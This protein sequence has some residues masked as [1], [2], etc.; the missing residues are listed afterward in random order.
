MSRTGLS[1][2]QQASAHAGLGLFLLECVL[3]GDPNGVAAASSAADTAA[4]AATAPDSGPTDA[5]SGAVETQPGETTDDS[6]PTPDSSESAEDQGEAEGLESEDDQPRNDDERKLSRRER[7]RLREQE[8]IDKAIADALAAKDREREQAEETRKR[9]ETAT[10]AE[11]ARRERVS[12]FVGTQEALTSLNSEIDTLQKQI[13]D[14]IV[15]PNG[16]DLEDLIAQANAKRAHRDRWLENQSFQTELQADIWSQIEADYAYPATFPELADPKARAAY[17][18]SQGGIRGAMDTLANA[19]RS[20]KDREWQAKLDTQAKETQTK[21]K[22]LEADRDGWR[23]RAGGGTVGIENA[24]TPSYSAGTLTPE[25]YAAM[26]STDRAK[27]RATQDG[28]NQIDAMM[29]RAR[30]AA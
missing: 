30:G 1:S 26:D 5:A 3:E 25:R 20:H 6:A 18:H 17:L 14:E 13:N 4:P 19:I 21:L 22:A 16:A 8:R 12:Q 2:H 23:V 9:Q 24:G 27:L 10:A 7:Q 15:T 11:K 29:R 28:R